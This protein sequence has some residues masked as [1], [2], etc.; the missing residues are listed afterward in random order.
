MCPSTQI[1]EIDHFD[2]HCTTI[3]LSDDKKKLDTGEHTDDSVIKRSLI[4][5]RLA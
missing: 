4:V 3:M 2:R 5:K 1:I